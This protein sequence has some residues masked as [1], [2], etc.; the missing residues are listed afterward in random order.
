MRS[1]KDLSADYPVVFAAAGAA[2]FAGIAALYAVLF[3]NEASFD[4]K[5][6]LY[7]DISNFYWIQA[8]FDPA[9]FRGDP[10][11]VHALSRLGLFNT[12]AP[13]V[14]F[15]SLFMR[16][17]PYTYGLRLLSVLGCVAG[18]LMV[19]RLAVK[20]CARP[21]AALA[22]VVF[23]VYFLSMDTFFGVPRIYG[24]F[25]FLA[26][27]LAAEEKR[28][29]LLPFCVP[30]AF[31]VYPAVSVGIGFSALLAPL[32]AWPEPLPGPSHSS[33]FATL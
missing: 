15:T 21:A 1:I 25:A 6:A 30:A 31:I 20:S 26:F 14:W 28:F 19:F 7:T 11:A 12:E 18:T 29:L 2:L 32:T 17:T 10:L 24:F 27:L 33:H 13:W 8:L 5:Y 9:L 23:A 4:P 22:A 16:V 3:T